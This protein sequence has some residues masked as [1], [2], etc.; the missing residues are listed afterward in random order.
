MKNY[1]KKI[2]LFI[3]L[4]PALSFADQASTKEQAMDMA[5]KALALVKSQGAE[6]A[7][8]TFNSSNGEFHSQDLYV[9]AYDNKG[10]CLANGNKTQAVGRNLM[11]IKDT[12]GNSVVAQLLT[13]TNNGW[14]EYEWKEPSSGKLQHRSVYVLRIDA[15]SILGVGITKDLS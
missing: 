5:N 13:I 9:V 15:D 7:F 11:H 4:L 14:V 2:A 3:I 1:L 6:A 10:K 12:S 8:K